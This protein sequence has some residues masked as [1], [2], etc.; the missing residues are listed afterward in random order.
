MK[1][2]PKKNRIFSLVL[3]FLFPLLFLNAC[4]MPLSIRNLSLRR[5]VPA[6][7][8]TVRERL[9]KVKRKPTGKIYLNQRFGFEISYPED[10]LERE[11]Q[12]DDGVILKPSPT[13]SLEVRACG[14]YNLLSQTFDEIIGDWKLKQGKEHFHFKVIEE[15]PISIEVRKKDRVLEYQVG[16][17]IFWQCLKGN[18]LIKG[19]QILLLTKDLAYGIDNQVIYSLSYTL[20][21][22]YLPQYQVTL[23]QILKSFH[24]LVFPRE[25]NI[26]IEKPK[27]GDDINSP[28]RV[29][30]KARVF[31]AQFLV[32]VKD[33]RGNILGQESVMASAGAPEWGNFSLDLTFKQPE[34]NTTG[35]V[36]A[37]DLSPK[38]G[39]EI[40]LV[41]I[42]V[43]ILGTQH[44]KSKSVME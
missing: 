12:N 9:K 22:A 1:I 34:E 14:S 19:E 27:L 23:N 37:F 28:V 29:S 8:K 20:P 18:I 32:R 2:F 31:E 16:T 11:S 6:K 40:D 36:E 21:D 41:S 5:K 39:T 43:V 24:L 25:R 17:A 42:P 26:V 44:D 35:L 33:N 15:K 7:V 10:W 4:K 30:G 3:F 13:S 38:D